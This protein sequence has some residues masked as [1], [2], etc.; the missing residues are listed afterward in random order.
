MAPPEISRV[1]RSD[2]AEAEAAEG[3]D[4][5]KDPNRRPRRSKDPAWK[6][7]FMCDLEDRLQHGNY[8]FLLN[9]SLAESRLV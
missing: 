8:I 6:Y 3:Y 4:P 7:A 9:L 1:I 2:Q 5:F